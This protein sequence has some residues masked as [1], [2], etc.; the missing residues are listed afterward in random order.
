MS[1][2]FVGE[3]K[4]VSFSWAPK[5]WAICNGQLLPIN[6]NQPLFA[7]IGTTYGGDGRTTFAL[8][9]FRARTPVHRSQVLPPGAPGGEAAHT[10]ISSEMAAHGHGASGAPVAPDQPGPSGSLW[11]Q[12]Q[13]AYSTGSANA[14]MNLAGSAPAGGAQGHPNLPPYLVLNFII[15]LQGAFPHTN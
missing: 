12:T 5:G 1:M 6:Q 11:A 3:I 14:R 8:P 9:D 10:L 2:P 7:V 4:L 13:S 15:A